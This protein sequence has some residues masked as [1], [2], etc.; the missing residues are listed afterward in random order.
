[1][2]ARPDSLAH[3]GH[4][5]IRPLCCSY[6]FVVGAMLQPSMQGSASRTVLVQLQLDC[7]RPPAP[8]SLTHRDLPALGCGDAVDVEWLGLQCPA[9]VVK[10][11]DKGCIV[12][13]HGK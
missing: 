9:V 11:I 2:D 10:R 7:I 3:A 6:E 1:M 5:I 4:L 13:L 12:M 8:P